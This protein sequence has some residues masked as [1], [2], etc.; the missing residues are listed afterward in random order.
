[1][2]KTFKLNLSIKFKDVILTS[3]QKYQCKVCFSFRKNKDT[4]L[5]VRKFITKINF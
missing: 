3:N 2:L 1:M 5:A 4:S